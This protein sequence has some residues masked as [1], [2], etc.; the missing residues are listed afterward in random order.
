MLTLSSYADNGVSDFDLHSLVNTDW[1]KSYVTGVT[2]L[3]SCLGG[4]SDLGDDYFALKSVRKYSSSNAARW[5]YSLEDAEKKTYTWEVDVLVTEG[6]VVN[7]GFSTYNI[8]VMSDS[9]IRGQV[10]GATLDNPQVQNKPNQWRKVVLSYDE[11][12]R[13]M[14]SYVDGNQVGIVTGMDFHNLKYAAFSMDIGLS[15]IGSTVVYDNA[16]MYNEPYDPS[17]HINQ[18]PEISLITDVSGIDL[19]GDT[20]FYDEEVVSDVETILSSIDAGD[21]NISVFKDSTCTELAE[22]ELSGSECI[23]VEGTNGMYSY[24]YLN[25]ASLAIYDNKVEFVKEGSSVGAITKFTNTS[26]T[27]RT[28]VMIMVL[29]D[30]NGIIRKLAASR[31]IVVPSKTDNPDDAIVEISPITC[32]DYTPEVFFIESWSNR[33][34]LFDKIYS[35]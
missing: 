35:E 3:P 23:A 18:A 17:K 28:V 1:N 20:I 15:E 10:Q 5:K 16:I 26:S 21:S 6:A 11:S 30:E 13:Q 29:K 19:T 27:D 32:G 8:F 9:L 12:K 33:Q 14:Q 31:E 34:R 4:K 22:N 7:M 24:Y 2:D 25:K